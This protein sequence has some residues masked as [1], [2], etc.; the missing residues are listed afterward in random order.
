MLVSILV[1]LVLFIIAPRGLANS[2]NILSSNAGST[3][4]R[5][6]RELQ[7]S[8]HARMKPCVHRLLLPFKPISSPCDARLFSMS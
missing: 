6:T 4:C 3:S 1:F 2:L 8:M 5:A 7:L